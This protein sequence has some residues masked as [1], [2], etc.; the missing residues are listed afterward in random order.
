MVGALAL[1]VARLKEMVGYVKDFS[2][3]VRRS[4]LN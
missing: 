4:F 1:E 2:S 3:A